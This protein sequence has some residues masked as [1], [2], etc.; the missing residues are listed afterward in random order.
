[1]IHLEGTNL[2][3]N[4]QQFKAFVKNH[5]KLV[6]VVR[7]GEKTWQELF[8]EWYILGENDDSWIP[9]RNNN[10]D[11][12]NERKSKQE[13]P[14][15]FMS[16]LFASMKKIDVNKIQG[17]IS[18]VGNTLATIQQAI[19]QF[20]SFVPLDRKNNPSQAT[21]HPFTFRKD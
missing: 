16:S 20:Q 17:Q 4:V 11:S 2:H 7:K 12:E 13:T 10:N 8:E 21:K 6:Q 1:M 14:H 9:Y 18:N 3:P 19:H 15:D 5:Q